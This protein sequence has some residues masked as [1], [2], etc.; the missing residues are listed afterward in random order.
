MSTHELE[1]KLILVAKCLTPELAEKTEEKEDADKF[2]KLMAS[3]EKEDNGK[4]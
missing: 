4:E 2:K 1:S 3:L